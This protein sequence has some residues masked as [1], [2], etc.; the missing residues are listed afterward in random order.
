MKSTITD[1][2]KK[3]KA[4]KPLVLNQADASSS[5]DDDDDEEVSTPIPG[6]TPVK[7]APVDN[8]PVLDTKESTPVLDTKESSIDNGPT[9][10]SSEYLTVGPET[11]SLPAV[12][13]REKPPRKEIRT[14][15][16]AWVKLGFGPV[17][18]YD[19]EVRNKKKSP[20]TEERMKQA[21]QLRAE[22]H[23]AYKKAM[24]EYHARNP[25][26]AARK[27]PTSTPKASVP[28]Q[29]VLVEKM[30][31]L[32][33]KLSSLEEKIDESNARMSQLNKR[34]KQSRD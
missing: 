22:S 34:L 15:A 6:T 4:G 11:R 2:I 20:E 18:S 5:S 16:D 23:D 13:K 27:S 10:I 28:D 12:N 8:T 25:P 30:K 33:E 32:E 24:E 14:I 9:I 17:S 19:E 21:K 3:K 1:L 31:S 7:K 26:K 29:G